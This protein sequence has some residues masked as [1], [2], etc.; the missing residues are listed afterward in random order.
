MFFIDFRASFQAKKKQLFLFVAYTIHLHLS[1]ELQPDCTNK[2]L[3]QTLSLSSYQSNTNNKI[4]RS[5]VRDVVNELPTT[6]PIHSFTSFIHINLFHV[7]QRVF[8]H[9]T[10]YACNQALDNSIL[11]LYKRMKPLST[12][13]VIYM[14]GLHKALFQQK[15]DASITGAI[16]N[17]A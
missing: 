14:Y 15:L 13:A 7:Y 8:T 6:V 2:G 1:S 10:S 12:A 3:Q 9:E 16:L 11:R 4:K 17:N 5:L